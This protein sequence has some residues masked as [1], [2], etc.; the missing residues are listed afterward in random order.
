VMSTREILEAH[1]LR[2]TRQRQLIIES[3]R[4]SR[5]HPTAEDIFSAVRESE[6]GLSFA[7][8]YNVL[9][10]LTAHGLARRIPC[11]TGSGPCRFDG[12]VSEHAHIAM[13]E[14]RVID[15]PHDLNRRVL[16]SLPGSLV[17]EIEQRTGVRVRA[18]NVQFLAAPGQACQG[19]P[20]DPAL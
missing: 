9:E 3:L 6:P 16:E 14:G 17:D 15:V 1:G 11:P 8:V 20:P 13:P 12:D 7:T 10:A 18:V 5:S 4:A 19:V 2:F